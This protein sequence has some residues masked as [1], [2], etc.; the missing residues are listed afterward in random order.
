MSPTQKVWEV[1]VVTGEEKWP[2][3]CPSFPL[4]SPVDKVP[5][6]ISPH[7]LQATLGLWALDSSSC[8]YPHHCR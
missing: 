2:S 1:A 5:T 7:R 8:V 4:T 6:H 3:S